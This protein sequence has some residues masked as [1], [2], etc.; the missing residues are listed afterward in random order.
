MS[1]SLI[2]GPGGPPRRAS[3][4]NP[5]SDNFWIRSSVSREGL[6]S[7]KSLYSLATKRVRENVCDG[8][9]TNNYRI[10]NMAR[11]NTKMRTH[12]PLCANP[13]RQ[14]NIFLKETETWFRIICGLQCCRLVL[15]PCFLTL[16]P[17]GTRQCPVCIEQRVDRLARMVRLRNE[18]RLQNCNGNTSDVPCCSR[19]LQSSSKRFCHGM[20]LR[21]MRD[22]VKV[23]QV[24]L[25]S[26]G[27]R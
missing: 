3:Q 25:R 20:C 18:W 6:P 21:M 15:P 2:L 19:N 17:I 10:D 22:E 27:K 11:T 1:S 7:I 5:I 13:V 16:Y 24:I 12:L 9:V 26:S 23:S 14:L 8:V 4:I